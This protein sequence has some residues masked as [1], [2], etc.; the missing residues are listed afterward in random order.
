MPRYI[1]LLA[2]ALIGVNIAAANDTAPPTQLESI[3]GI[4]VVPSAVGKDGK[5]LTELQRE[6]DAA[7]E[8]SIPDTVTA[9][10]LPSIYSPLARTDEQQRAGER[11]R[12]RYNSSTPAWDAFKAT[13]GGYT[14]SALRMLT[15]EEGSTKDADPSYDVGKGRFDF[16]SKY[17]M[18]YWD[19]YEHT[20]N[21]GQR[22]VLVA[23][24]DMEAEREAIKSRS[25]LGTALGYLCD[26]LLVLGA[27]LVFMHRRKT[28]SAH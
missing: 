24:L 4:L 2:L 21:E 1:L 25:L 22:Q 28:R 8:I 12:V 16:R 5:P 20:V 10:P 26:P 23:S 3:N 18:A 27:V 15:K 6:I 19:E 11:E 7:G 9:A 14:R 17:P 13:A